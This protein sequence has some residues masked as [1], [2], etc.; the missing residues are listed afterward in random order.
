V[1]FVTQVHSHTHIC[2]YIHTIHAGFLP[3]CLRKNS[4]G[5]NGTEGGRHKNETMLKNFY[6]FIIG[7]FT[8]ILPFCAE[9]TS[10][11]HVR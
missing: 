9:K 2:V 11:L 3:L 1:D 10:L 4:Q 6:L 8:L 7:A 5:D